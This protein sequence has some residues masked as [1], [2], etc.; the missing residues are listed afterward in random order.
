M[1]PHLII[2]SPQLA[3]QQQQQQASGGGA[4]ANIA[5]GG[6]SF[7]I[8]DLRNN[9]QIA[10][11]RAQLAADPSSIQPLIQQLAH[12]NPEI[13]QAIAQ[14]PE[15]L[16]QLLAPDDEEGQDGEQV[17]PGAQVLNVTPEERDAIQRVSWLDCVKTFY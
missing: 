3:Q 5:S 16:L 10:Q 15:A 2:Y 9:P 12:F 14:N 4:G 8:A 13:A 11:L 17:P 6:R 1:Q 7:N